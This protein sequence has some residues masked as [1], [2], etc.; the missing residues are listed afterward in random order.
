MECD[1]QLLI[2]VEIQPAI[3]FGVD[4]GWWNSSRGRRSEHSHLEARLIGL[5]VAE[6]TWRCCTGEFA[7]ISRALTGSAACGS[8]LSWPG[9]RFGS[10]RAESPALWAA[11]SIHPAPSQPVPEERRSSRWS[12]GRSNNCSTKRLRLA[13]P[14]R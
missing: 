12:C 14:S 7:P 13:V 10:P 8:E 3:P 1:L 4:G 2:D 5:G 11:D 6:N 9:C